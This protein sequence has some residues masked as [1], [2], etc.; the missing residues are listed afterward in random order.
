M[1][2]T[3][4]GLDRFVV[5]WMVGFCKV[6]RRS[7]RDDKQ[8]NKQQQRQQQIPFGDD[9]QK[10]ANGKRQLQMKL[11]LQLQ[12]QNTG[13]LRLRGSQS[14]VSHFAQDD[15]GGVEGGVTIDWR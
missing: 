8:K 12:L 1:S 9:N 15:D 5:D 13:I 4:L 3:V 7:L 14:A 11:Q 2:C 10:T 6:N